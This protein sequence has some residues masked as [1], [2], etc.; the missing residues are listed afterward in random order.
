MRTATIGNLWGGLIGVKA[1]GPA[2]TDCDA[3]PQT[4]YQAKITDMARPGTKVL[5]LLSALAYSPAS[6]NNLAE[7]TGLTQRKVWG[8]LKQ[9]K[10]KGMVTYNPDSGIWQL[11]REYEGPA[12]DRACR[13]LE[14]KGWLCIPPR[15]NA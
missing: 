9:P 8:L 7:T 11:N 10:D 12:I 4:A 6:T 1:V 14:S 2:K 13:L 5:E 15:V 3:P